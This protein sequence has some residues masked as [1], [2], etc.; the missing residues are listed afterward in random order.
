MAQIIPIGEPANDGERRAI[1]WLRDHAPDEWMVLHN[2]EIGRHGRWFEIDLA[3]LTPHVVYLVDVKGTVGTVEVAQSR[4]YPEGRAPFFSPVR[5]LRDHAREFKGMAVEG[6]PQADLR[7][8]YVEAAVLLVGPG[9]HLVDPEGRDAPYVAALEECVAFFA[10]QRR[11][12]PAFS[13]EISPLLGHVRAFV[14]G[15]ARP[16]QGPLRFGHWVVVEKLGSTDEVTEYRARN[17]FAP[18]PAG[19][20]LLRIYDADPYLPDAERRAQRNRI[21]N[22]YT[23]LSRLPAHPNIVSALDFFPTEGDEQFVL[24]TDDVPGRALRLHLA[25]GPP[26]D[27]RPE[28]AAGAWAAQRARARAR[29][30]GG[31]PGG[32]PVVGAGGAG[33]ACLPDQ[34]RVCPRRR[35][36]RL[37]GRRGAVGTGRCRLP[38]A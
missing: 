17:S 6:S 27:A 7:R 20:A 22:A 34:L 4:W 8:L 29:P 24:V 5:K 13:R 25:P 19:S 26:A 15:R 3:V 36:A 16:R 21:A 10:D 9:A 1:R 38:G 35:G 28:A 14:Q 18:P 12:P 30:P 2:F 32:E 31:A 33:R 37:H 11:V 23:A